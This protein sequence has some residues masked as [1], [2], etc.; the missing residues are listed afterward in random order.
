M[1]GGQP[2]FGDGRLDFFNIIGNPVKFPGHPAGMKDG[3]R[4]AG[5][6]IA[7]LSHAAG[8]QDGAVFKLDRFF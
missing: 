5:V 2:V 3:V 1:P 8:V 6:V 4:C 7:R